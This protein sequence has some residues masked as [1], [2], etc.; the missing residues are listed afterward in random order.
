M[1]KKTF[2]KKNLCQ[3]EEPKQSTT[4][5]IFSIVNRMISAGVCTTHTLYRL[6]KGG[7]AYL[8]CAIGQLLPVGLQA[9]L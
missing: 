9:L 1:K 2:K 7:N 5:R 4:T 8:E 6:L 3:R